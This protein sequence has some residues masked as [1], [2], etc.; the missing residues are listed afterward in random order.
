M[1]KLTDDSLMTFGQHRDKK[2]IRVPAE[3][4]LDLYDNKKAPAGLRVYIKDNLLALKAEASRDAKKRVAAC[5]P[6]KRR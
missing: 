1:A 5:Q 3:Y 2:L 6:H 4:L